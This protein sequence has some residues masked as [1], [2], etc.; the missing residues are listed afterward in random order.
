MPKIACPCA[1]AE[2]T[3][4]ELSRVM[5]APIKKTPV[6]IECLRLYISATTPVWISNRKMAVSR[7]VPT[8]TNF[9]SSPVLTQGTGLS[10]QTGER[11]IP[12]YGCDRSGRWPT[13]SSQRRLPENHWEIKII[14][15]YHHTC[16][17]LEWM[18]VA[19]FGCGAWGSISCKAPVPS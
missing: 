11:S 10:Q 9:Y 2:K 4:S 8:N 6:M 16:A 7:E 14:R 13:T 17:V 12:T 18:P 19:P 3:G 1:M 15:Q 5:P